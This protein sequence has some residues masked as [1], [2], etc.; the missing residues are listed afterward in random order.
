MD[1]WRS[2][3]KLPYRPPFGSQLYTDF[4]HVNRL[5]DAR[6]HHAAHSAVD[7]RLH[8]FPKKRLA[9][10]WRGDAGNEGSAVKRRAQ[11]R[12]GEAAWIPRILGHCHPHDLPSY[13]QPQKT[14]GWSSIPAQ[15]FK[16]RRIQGVAQR[17]LP[18]YR[19]HEAGN[20]IDPH[21]AGRKQ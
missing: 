10:L 18:R 13:V 4:H 21:R 5:N 11:V 8:S 9:G 17:V 20:A 6:G 19:G 1:P 7:E 12:L 2:A 15:I 16:P 14:R 3:G